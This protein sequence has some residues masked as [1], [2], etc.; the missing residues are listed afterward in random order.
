MN[1]VYSTMS[2]V[3]YIAARVADVKADVDVVVTV[4][5]NAGGSFETFKLLRPVFRWIRA[6][7]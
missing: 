3:A 4:A 2:G 1:V 7:G 6:A 5:A